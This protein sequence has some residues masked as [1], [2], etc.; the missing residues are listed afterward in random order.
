MEHP[1]GDMSGPDRS[2]DGRPLAPPDPAP[3][4]VPEGMR[5]EAFKAMG[6]TV[7]VLLPAARAAAGVAAVQALFD[8]WERTLSRFQPESELSRLNAC[9]GEP[10]AVSGLL[11]TV[12]MNALAAADATG[13]LYD[14]TLLNQLVA[15]G[16]DRD[17]DALPA[18][19]RPSAAR[20]RPGGH[21]RDVRVDRSRRSVTLPA[22]IALD[23]GGIA[24]GMAVDAALAR[25]RDMG[26]QPALVNAGGDLAVLGLPPGYESWPL[27]VPGRD[28]SWT[29]PLIHGAMA[30][31]GVAHRH[32]TQG[33][34]RR[35]HLLDPR[36]GL[37]ATGGL[38]SVSVVASRCEQAE[39]AAKV[40]FILGPKRGA[41]FLRERRLA[42]L[43]VREDGGWSVAGAWPERLVETTQ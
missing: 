14:P 19:Q 6:T 25:L 15:L 17:F 41:A 36:T 21:W 28:T 16:Y 35:H 32:W 9:A 4:V 1:H 3:F 2:H 8:E 20:P 24:K 27:A 11:C 34:E 43:L 10:V 13:G 7:S 18:D 22:G 40:A 23:F 26:I 38:W 29:V 30:T 5:A 37:P 39:V 12:L 42:G 33:G 31:S